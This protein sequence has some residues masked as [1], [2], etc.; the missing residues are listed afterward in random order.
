MGACE[1]RLDPVSCR[2]D[3]VV[4]LLDRQ[5]QVGLTAL[6][7]AL[8]SAAVATVLAV[9]AL[10]AS[11][12]RI[13]WPGRTWTS[14][15]GPSGRRLVD[16]LEAYRASRAKDMGL[17]Q[18]S[19]IRHYLP[20]ARGIIAEIDEPNA[21]VLTDWLTTAIDTIIDD[22]DEAER[23]SD[24]HRLRMEFPPVAASWLSHPER[25][26][27]EPFLRGSEHHA[28]VRGA[29][30]GLGV[31]DDS[32]GINGKGPLHRLRRHVG[33]C[34]GDDGNRTRTISLED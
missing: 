8:I 1:E 28:R 24:R 3:V 12:R 18:R 6:V 2:L 30:D 21:E 25:F 4:T 7:I 13:G 16:A 29:G 14:S 20:L 26:R 32:D 34:G 11:A 15:A 33:P 10:R 19:G 23:R 5:G 31:I 27:P 17:G 22:P 9:A